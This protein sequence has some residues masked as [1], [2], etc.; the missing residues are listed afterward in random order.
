MKRV[1]VVLPFE[2]VF[3]SFF[4]GAIARWVYEVYSRCSTI[5][6]IIIGRIDKKSN[7]KIESTSHPYHICRYLFKIP[8]VRRCVHRIYL[9]QSLGEIRGSD[10][11]HVHNAPKY[12]IYLNKVGIKS[13]IIL[14]MHNNYFSGY[15]DRVISALEK[16]DFEILVCSAFLKNEIGVRSSTLH[17]RVKVIPNGV[18][19]T[20]FAA[21]RERRPSEVKTITYVGRVAEGKGLQELL[22]ALKIISKKSILFKLK[23]IGTAQFGQ[24][25]SGEYYERCVSLASS[26]DKDFSKKAVHWMGYLSHDMGLAK[27]ITS[28]DIYVCPSICDEAFGMSIVEA[29]ACG[30]PVIAFDSGGIREL[31]EGVGMLVNKGDV[32][33]LADKIEYLISEEACLNDMSKR[34]VEKSKGY[35]WNVVVTSFERYLAGES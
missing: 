14:H 3:S 20:S 33:S 24:P 17:E 7:F 27:E 23:I 16:L 34:S 6:K 30:L 32:K 9:Y 2:E 11:V 10:V 21:L 15:D 31:V 18:D 8:Y 25:N 12:V 26:I 5:N 1:A 28:S 35:D 4:G 22:L 19:L 29:M 13:K